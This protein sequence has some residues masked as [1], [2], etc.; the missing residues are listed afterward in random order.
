MNGIS[1]KATNKVVKYLFHGGVNNRLNQMKEIGS[2]PSE[3]LKAEEE[4]LELSR[5]IFECLP[6][7]LKR[8]W[9]EIGQ[10]IIQ[11][12]CR[13]SDEEMSVFS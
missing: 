9:I 1:D 12:C 5:N 8:D 11:W 3:V 2:I 4:N 6:D 10:T 13:I 7:Y